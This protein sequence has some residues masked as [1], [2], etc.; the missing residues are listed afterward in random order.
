MSLR[1]GLGPG[2]FGTK[3]QPTMTLRHALQIAGITVGT[4]FLVAAAW[5]LVIGPLVV[6]LVHA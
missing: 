6:L 5:V 2:T 3:M 4:L 1:T